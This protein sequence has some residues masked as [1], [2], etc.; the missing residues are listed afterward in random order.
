VLVNVILLNVVI[1]WAF[2][3]GIS[4]GFSRLFAPAYA[5][6]KRALIYATGHLVISGIAYGLAG[7]LALGVSAAAN[8]TALVVLAV[9]LVIVINFV[10]QTVWV[11]AIYRTN[12]VVAGLF[13]LTLFGFHAVVTG[14]ISGSYIEEKS[15]GM[16]TQFMDTNVTSQLQTATAEVKH[17]GE[18]AQAARDKVQAATT[19][20]QNEIAQD[21][22]DEVSLNQ[23]IAEKQKTEN[24][25]YVRIVRLHAEGKLTEARDQ[26]TDF[27]STFPNGALNSAAKA[28]LAQVESEMAA[29]DAAKKQADADATKA[30]EQARADLLARAQKEGVPLSE[31]RQALIGKS[32]ADV[33]ALF[34]PPTDT[35][36]DRWGY[37]Q[38]ITLNPLT[39]EKHGLTV[40]FADGV[41]Q[42]V[43]YYYVSGGE[44]Q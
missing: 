36:S 11:V 27:L 43:D 34:G 29:Q 37:S 1:G 38:Q 10:M 41:V 26:F 20:A 7:L 32:R 23:Q 3:V 16:L 2:N 22:A 44:S 19:K 18:V 21:A 39:N 28:Q 17:D 31:M 33:T 12:A 14:L 6:I 30:A 13:Y 25:D 40:Y 42:G 9:V 35:A 4:F 15:K 5:K 24:F 8:S